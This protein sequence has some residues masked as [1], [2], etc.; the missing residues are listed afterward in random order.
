MFKKI[1]SLLFIS[2]LVFVF[3]LSFNKKTSASEKPTWWTV[4]S[5]DTMK[6][7][8][9]LSREKLDDPSFDD[10]I[11][12][13]VSQIAATGA[14]HVAIATPYDEEFYPILKRW[15]VA[16]RAHHLKVWFRGNWSGWEE[17][18]NY[19]KITRAEHIKKTEE[20]ILK[21][22]DIFE[23]GDVFT[24]CPECENGGPGDPRMN[25][26]VDGFRQFMI[27][28]YKVTKTS[29]A[30]IN[31]N[32][33]SNYDSMNGDVARLVMDKSTTQ[34]MDGIVAV[35]HYVETPDKLVGDLEQISQNSGG[36]IVL[37]EFGAPIPD[38]NGDMTE[39]EQAAWIKSA[40]SKL[41]DSPVVVGVNYWTNMGSSTSIWNDNGTPRK[42][43]DALKSIYSAPVIEGVVVDE[44]GGGIP[45]AYVA[46]GNRTYITDLGGHY[47][48]SY[49]GENK[50]I[51]VS[52][53]GY[54]NKQVVM[55][56]TKK[57]TIVLLSVKE[58]FWFK[59]RKFIHNLVPFL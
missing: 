54:Y 34:A 52:S 24:A 14:T 21:H 33:I 56:Q 17:W 25:G 1:I 7:S 59:V 18:F 28:E 3:L 4:Q 55:D 36:R 27:D 32:V 13:Q 38:I 16:A 23:D 50:T 47:A 46:V 53:Q 5:V 58:S 15:V 40:L 12:K 19:P 51:T 30:K 10:V 57:Q 37:G 44:A 29:F 31:K 35:D 42:A 49:F 45:N 20:F 8:R 43:V 2:F 22:K 41:V 9:D 11:D 26:D 39:D 6:Y 48:F